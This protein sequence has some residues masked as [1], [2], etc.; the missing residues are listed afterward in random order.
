MVRLELGIGPANG[1]LLGADVIRVRCG[2][3]IDTVADRRQ[4]AISTDLAIARPDDVEYLLVLL[5][6]RVEPALD[7]LDTVEVAALGSFMAMTRNVGAL[8]EP[9]FRSLPI[10]TPFS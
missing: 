8:P 9:G 2:L 6:G 4:L 7:D 5:A 3:Q 1:E 10:G